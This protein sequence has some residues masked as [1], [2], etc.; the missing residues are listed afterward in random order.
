MTFQSFLLFIVEVTYIKKKKKHPIHHFLRPKQWTAHRTKGVLWYPNE[1]VAKLDLQ[2]THC[3]LD[4]PSA[5]QT[6]PLGTTSV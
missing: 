2:L 3:D 5:T 4:F 1:L 6:L